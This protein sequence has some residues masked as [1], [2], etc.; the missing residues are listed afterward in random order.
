[1]ECAAT[2]LYRQALLAPTLVEHFFN[3]IL[4]FFPDWRSCEWEQLQCLAE[5]RNPFTEGSPDHT[6]ASAHGHRLEDH[7]SRS[8]RNGPR[9]WHT[10]T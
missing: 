6:R 3:L 7:R 5:V 10:H 2:P 1:M 4:T 9:R 8:C